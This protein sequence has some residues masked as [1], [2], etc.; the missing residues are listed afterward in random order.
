MSMSTLRRPSRTRI[1]VLRNLHTGIASISNSSTSFTAH[2]TDSHRAAERNPA[3]G[4]N[5]RRMRPHRQTCRHRLLSRPASRIAGQPRQP[6]GLHQLRSAVLSREVRLSANR[7]CLPVPLRQPIRDDIYPGLDRRA[8]RKMSPPH[9]QPLPR[10]APPDHSSPPEWH[11][12]Y[13]S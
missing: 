5:R 9:R 10:C 12:M 2:R 8:D 3:V 1:T 13:A 11:L 4:C 6:S 7:Q